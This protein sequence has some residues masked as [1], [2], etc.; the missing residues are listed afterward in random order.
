MATI[1]LTEAPTTAT[2]T[3]PNPNPPSTGPQVKILVEG[4]NSLEDIYARCWTG[5]E[6][7]RR[8]LSSAVA[9]LALAT[10]PPTED[11]DDVLAPSAEVIFVTE[12]PL[13]VWSVLVESCRCHYFGSDWPEEL[14]HSYAVPNSAAL[15]RG[16]VRWASDEQ[17]AA[18]EKLIAWLEARGWP[19]EG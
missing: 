2:I 14:D 9:V 15:R 19:G 10:S 3:I 12:N 1:T 16:L 6:H 11:G 4:L 13:R 17:L 7:C 18:V 8:D 5:E